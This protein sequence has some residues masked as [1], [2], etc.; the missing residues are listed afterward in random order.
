MPDLADAGIV[1]RGFMTVSNKP[2]VWCSWF[3]Y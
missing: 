1:H 2:L 3:K